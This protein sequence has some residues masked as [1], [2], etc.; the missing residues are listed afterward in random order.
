[1]RLLG[2][3]TPRSTGPRREGSAEECQVGRTRFED[4][5]SL[6]PF[7]PSSFHKRACGGKGLSFLRLGRFFPTL[8]RFSLPPSIDEQLA[9]E[10][11]RRNPPWSE[12]AVNG[13][14]CDGGCFEPSPTSLF[15][16][17][18]TRMPPQ[19]VVRPPSPPGHREGTPFSFDLFVVVVF[20][21]RLTRS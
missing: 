6:G 13:T 8:H 17:S 15:P 3:A 21:S 5:P 1:M 20:A 10:T 16:P 18:A 9:Q 11:D 4:A 2:P 12:N 7:V 19:H 14:K